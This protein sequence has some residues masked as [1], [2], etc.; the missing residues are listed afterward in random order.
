MQLDSDKRISLNILGIIQVLDARV[1]RLYSLR[2]YFLIHLTPSEHLVLG[3]DVNLVENIT[4]WYESIE[5]SLRET[6]ANVMTPRG[7][8]LS[9]GQPS[10]QRALRVETCP[11][12]VVP[13]QAGQKKLPIAY[14]VID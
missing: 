10:E 11:A 7:L 8:G 3:V 9:A 12:K 14:D 1:H 4:T 5:S 2:S 13:E 6:V